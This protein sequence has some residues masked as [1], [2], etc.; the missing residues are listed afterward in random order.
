M[1][2]Y[3]GLL[4]IMAFSLNLTSCGQSP[5]D[6]QEKSNAAFHPIILDQQMVSAETQKR[7]Q[8]NTQKNY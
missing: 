1:T 7:E 3:L 4:T 8:K 6:K 5:V 2:I